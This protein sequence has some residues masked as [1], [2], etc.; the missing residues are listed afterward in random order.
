MTWDLQTKPE[1]IMDVVSRLKVS[2]HQ[3]IF[4]ADFEYG[5]QPLRWEAL[6]NG[7]GAVAHQPGQGGVQLSTTNAAGDIAIRQS[8]LYHRYQPG[9]TMFMA[10]A[11]LFG[12]PVTNAVQRVG[13]FDDSNGVFWEQGTSTAS[14]PAGMYFVVRSDIGGTV[15]ETRVSYED[16]RDPNGTKATLNWN[17]IQMIFIEYAWYGAGAVR[18]GIYSNGEMFILHQIGFGNRNGQT[19]AWSRTGNLPARY[20]LRNKGTAS[21]GQTMTHYGLSVMVE[22]RNDD[23]RGFTYSYGMNQSNMRKTVNQ[24]QSRIPVLSIRP[25]VMG[26]QEYTQSNSA[27]T[28]GTTTTLTVT[29]T[30]WTVD[31]WK[32]RCVFF[33]G[34]GGG[35]GL[36]ARIT[37]NTTSTLTFEDVV[38]GAALSSAPGTASNYQIGLINRGQLLPQDLY[39]SSSALCLVELISSTPTSP[40]ALTNSSWVALNT[41]GSSSSFAERDLSSTALSGGE[42]IQAFTAP[43]GGSG[44]QIISLRNLFPIGTT[45]RGNI[46]DIL[47]LAIS[48]PSGAAADVGAHFVCQ[49][50]MS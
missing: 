22:G 31:Q 12:Q 32:G 29:G 26:T 5:P 34:L 48:T 42:V 19:T 18:F 36:T 47:T 7:S 13:M 37:G 50:A 14:N 11:V 28:S 21:S 41:I 4:D 33:P 17:N 30:P 9:K 40:V 8:R 2:V 10:S 49:E 39:I 35:N 25:R 45:I 43:A 16:W 3:N 44:L 38:T 24:N 20:E 15:N 6:T 1:K 46:P 23:Q 27:A